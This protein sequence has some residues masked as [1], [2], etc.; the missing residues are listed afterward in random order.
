MFNECKGDIHLDIPLCG[1]LLA[2]VTCKVILGAK[3]MG[4]SSI[5]APR[6]VT[7]CRCA[8]VRLD[9]GRPVSS[10]RCYHLAVCFR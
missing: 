8:G 9:S 4:L 6:T 7:G 5:G 1:K 10:P 2:L 3:T